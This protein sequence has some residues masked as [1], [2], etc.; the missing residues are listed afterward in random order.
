MLSFIS[1]LFTLTDIPKTHRRIIEKIAKT[2]NCWSCKL[3]DFNGYEEY[4]AFSPREKC[5]FV[6]SVCEYQNR[7]FKDWATQRFLVGLLKQKLPFKETEILNL[8]AWHTKRNS[9]YCRNISEII[10]ILERH[11]KE[12]PLTDELKQAF[13]ICGCG[14][15]GSQNSAD[16]TETV[17]CA[18]AGLWLLKVRS[19]SAKL[20]GYHKL[21]IQRWTRKTNGI[22]TNFIS[23]SL[24]GG[25]RNRNG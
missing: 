25:R 11:L 3:E 16:S 24:H 22:G 5:E 20:V 17:R 6:F 12:N 10:K 8:L 14:C 23:L 1:K 13:P 21:P 7:L 15:A 2:Q 4:S 19:S 18:F 9:N